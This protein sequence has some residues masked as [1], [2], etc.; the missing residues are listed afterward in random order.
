MAD[1]VGK[2]V[3]L[4]AAVAG[5]GDALS[6]LW[7]E[8][9]RWVAAVLLAHRPPGADLEDLL[10]DVAVT[11]VASVRSLRDA[12]AFRP[13]LR[14]V[15]INAARTAARRASVQRRTVG[16]LPEFPDAWPAD[17]QRG[18]DLRAAAVRERLDRV[19]EILQSMHADYREPM[20]LRA[21]QG[22]SQQQIADALHLPVT[23]IETRLARG[24]RMLRAA[25][26]QDGAPV[27]QRVPEDDDHG[28]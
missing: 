20:W 22:M 10:Q 23:T 27:P 3:L 26:A 12:A 9:R 5:C 6:Q 24:R 8:H 15:A 17:P 11:F 18:R 19:L 13:W 4:A 21:V 16:A 2:D 28:T 14:T 25:L 1:P 7:R